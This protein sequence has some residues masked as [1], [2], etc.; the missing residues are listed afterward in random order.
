MRRDQEEKRR[1]RREG[2]RDEETEE[3]GREDE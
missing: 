1:D 3:T 2:G